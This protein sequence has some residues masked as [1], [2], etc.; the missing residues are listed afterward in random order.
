MDVYFHDGC[1]SE[2]AILLLA[3][4]IARDCPTWKIA[5]HPLLE[6]EA[7]ARGRP[8]WKPHG[9]CFRKI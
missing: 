2:P 8:I 3:R 7:K 5:V 6:H 4:D 9:N 1:L